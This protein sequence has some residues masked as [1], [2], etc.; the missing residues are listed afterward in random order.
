MMF[1]I[2][3]DDDAPQLLQMLLR[4]LLRPLSL[5]ARSL[6]QA[7]VSFTLEMVPLWWRYWL[8]TF[9]THFKVELNLL[10]ARK[11]DI[12]IYV[13]G[14]PWFGF[15]CKRCSQPSG[16]LHQKKP[17]EQGRVRGWKTGEQTKLVEKL[18]FLFKKT[19]SFNIRS[20]TPPPFSLSGHFWTM[21]LPTLL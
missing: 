11:E 3:H 4:P 15:G 12:F 20:A 9:S 2:K 10:N 18:L 16:K 1:H 19:L 13:L 5:Q 6:P 8:N 21:T 17:V 7:E 14:E